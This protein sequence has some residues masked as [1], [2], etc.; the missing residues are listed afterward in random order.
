MEVPMKT[1][2]S[3][4]AALLLIGTAPA[5][6]S[7]ECPQDTGDSTKIGHARL[8]IEDNVP[9]E[10][11]GVHGLFDD[12][13]WRIL[14]LYAPDGTEILSFRPAGPLH[15]LG[16]AGFFFE[17]NEPPYDEWDYDALKATF[18]EGDY[19]VRGINV[20]GTHLSGTARFTTVVALPPTIL[21]PDSI[22][23]EDG[24]LPVVPFDD[25]VVRWAPSTQSRDGRPVDIAGYE[26]ILVN[27]DWEGS[28]DSFANPV[29]DVHVGPDRTELLVP[30]GFFDPETVYEIE[31]IAIEA[32]GN[33]T[34]AGASFFQTGE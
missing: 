23:E 28:D 32:S 5:F 3:I 20:D 19:T 4:I 14:C 7:T 26:V 30:K 10:D 17:S 24:D 31:I 15:E 1:K 33:Q 12:H 2:P 11:I 9:D 21:Y 13:G 29:Y 18:A 27:E 22:P 6:A 16:I 25:M 34:I 8:Y